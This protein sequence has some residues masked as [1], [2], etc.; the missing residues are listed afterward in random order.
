MKS[1]RCII[2]MLLLLAL[3]ASAQTATVEV[4]VYDR[5]GL[6]PLAL[7]SFVKQTQE[8]FFE[9]GL[10]IPIDVCGSANPCQVRSTGARIRMLRIVA[11]RS[12][13]MNNV[14]RSPLGQSFADHRGGTYASV[15]L[16][17]VQQ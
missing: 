13:K 7:Q 5:T 14:L 4:Q 15:F 8:I 16:E 11:G 3:R 9:A 10:A 1:R 6:S 2:P 17:P 12:R